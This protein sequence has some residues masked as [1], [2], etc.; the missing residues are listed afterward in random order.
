MLRAHGLLPTTDH[1]ATL[2]LH[3]AAPRLLVVEA[4]FALARRLAVQ[5]GSGAHASR[6]ALHAAYAR[7]MRERQ[8]GDATAP[9][10]TDP[11][12]YYAAL[13]LDAGAGADIIE[14][15]YALLGRLQ[16]LPER[17]AAR[18]VRDEAYRVLTNPQLR[19][20]YDHDRRAGTLWQT[21]R[22]TLLPLDGA[23][24][25]PRKERS[26]VENK[27]RGLFGF[28][29]ER[30]APVDA[31]D[32]R[33]LGLRDILS[34]EPD[35]PLADPSDQALG[36]DAAPLAEMVFTAGPRAGLRVE[37]DGNVVSF[38]DGRAT[39]SVWRHNDRFLLRHNGKHVRV[40]GA[41]PALTVVVL[42]DGDEIAFGAE[43]AR[44]VV[45]PEPA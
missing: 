37:L 3:P 25:A 24:Q 6:R 36:E 7:A 27:K 5:A 32:A 14:L 15:A 45:T 33:L 40:G 31:R 29:R 18:Y 39:A 20:R 28:G 12:D 41:T 44:F 35:E 2:Q 17:S 30:A 22:P 1:H 19:A 26:S 4:Y 43:R 23:G 13:C 8:E 42:E 9:G 38:A 34:V 10:E 21:P 16:P 11:H